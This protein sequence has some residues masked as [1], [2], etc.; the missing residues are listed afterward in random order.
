MSRPLLAIVSALTMAGMTAIAGATAKAA[1]SVGTLAL[2]AE[3]SVAYPSADCPSGT[4]RL[5]ECFVRSGNAIVPGLGSVEESYV[6]VLENAPPGCTAPP[7]ADAVRL[8]ATTA[9]FTVTG[10]G[11]IYLRTSGT[12]LT[13]AR[14]LRSTEAFTITGARDCTREPPAAARW[15]ACLTGRPLSRASIAGPGR[16]SC[17][18]GSSTSPRRPSTARP[19]SASGSLDA[20]SRSASSIR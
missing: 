5:F 17:P 12:G 19:T 2:R 3:A 10:K 13:R 7:G 1:D 11:E 14:T 4:A 18:V 8:P 16:S 6:Y 15:R 9:R 20:G